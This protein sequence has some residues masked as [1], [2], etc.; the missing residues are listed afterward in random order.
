MALVHG[1]RKADLERSIKL[2]GRKTSK[3][4]SISDWHEMTFKT[5]G[6]SIDFRE[7]LMFME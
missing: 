4:Q 7:V 1:F 2:Q 5:R 3:M 6:C